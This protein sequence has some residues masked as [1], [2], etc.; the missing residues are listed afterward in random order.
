[1]NIHLVRF[2]GL[3]PFFGE[4]ISRTTFSNPYF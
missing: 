3:G 1:M 4:Q 2:D